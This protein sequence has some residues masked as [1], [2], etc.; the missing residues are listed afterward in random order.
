MGLTLER[1]EASIGR[2]RRRATNGPPTYRA[3]AGKLARYGGDSRVVGRL[4]RAANVVFAGSHDRGWCLSTASTAI[5]FQ[6]ATWIILVGLA[7]MRIFRVLTQAIEAT[8]LPTRNASGRYGETRS[9]HRTRRF[10]KVTRTLY[11]WPYHL[12]LCAR[13]PRV[14]RLIG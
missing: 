14:L 4:A 9:G 10:V 5:G 6:P 12:E 13:R 3:S 8:G 11:S 2:T 1:H 7:R